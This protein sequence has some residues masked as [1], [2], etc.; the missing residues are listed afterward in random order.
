MVPVVWMQAVL[1]SCKL[2]YVDVGANKGDSLMDFAHSRPDQHIRTL[3][4]AALPDWHPTTTCVFALEANPRWTP[5]LRNVSRMLAPDVHSVSI[6][7]ETAAVEGETWQPVVLHDNGRGDSVGASVVV[8]RA[9]SKH[10]RSVLGVNFVDWLL[11]ATTPDVPVVVR[12]DVEGS[13]YSLLPCIASSGVGARRRLYVGIEW[14][15]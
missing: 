13:E 4:D 10:S 12:M 8:A 14:H 2:V 11:G 15:R 5:T 1:G 9:G 7:Y 6:L 3:L